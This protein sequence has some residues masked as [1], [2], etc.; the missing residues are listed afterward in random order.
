MPWFRNGGA[1][2]AHLFD[3]AHIFR[4]E[5]STVG[6]DNVRHAAEDLLVPLHGGHKKGMV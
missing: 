4:F 2:N 1:P 6:R 5:E 3:A